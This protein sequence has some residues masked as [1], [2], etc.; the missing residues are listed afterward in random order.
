MNGNFLPVIASTTCCFSGSVGCFQPEC[1]MVCP[2]AWRNMRTAAIRRRNLGFS[3]MACPFES[4]A[5]RCPQFDISQLGSSIFERPCCFRVYVAV[6]KKIELTLLNSDSWIL[7]A[8]FP[9]RFTTHHPARN[10]PA[11]NSNSFGGSA[12]RSHRTK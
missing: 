3:T 7:A 9:P 2:T 12:L 1:P 6:P 11:L 4:F 8:D 10:P 5:V